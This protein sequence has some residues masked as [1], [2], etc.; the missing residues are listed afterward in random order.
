VAVSLL[1]P[2]HGG[3]R[4]ETAVATFCNRF[5]IE[6]LQIYNGH[7]PAGI[8]KKFRSVVTAMCRNS[9]GRIIY[10]GVGVGAGI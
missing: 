10:S 9:R 3:F 2:L 5:E 7:S 1:K 8:S 4:S 6:R